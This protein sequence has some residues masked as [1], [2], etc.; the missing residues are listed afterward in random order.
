MQGHFL[1][2]PEGERNPYK[3]LVNSI[4]IQDNGT[5]DIF[6]NYREREPKALFPALVRPRH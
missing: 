1:E 5:I 2:Q 6:Y 3:L 4:V